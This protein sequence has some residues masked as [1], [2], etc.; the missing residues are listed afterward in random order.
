MPARLEYL[1]EVQAEIKQCR[2]L[3]VEI[4]DPET[5]RRLVNWQTK[6]RIGCAKWIA[7]KAASVG[8]LFHSLP[9]SRHRAGIPSLICWTP[10]PPPQGKRNTPSSGEAGA[11]VYSF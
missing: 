2:R 4:S 6:W 11:A 5:G 3:A 10:L 8:G 1:I 9:A 7:S